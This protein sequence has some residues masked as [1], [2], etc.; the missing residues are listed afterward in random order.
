MRTCL[1]VGSFNPVTLAHQK[2][3]YDLLEDKVIDYLYFL[4]VNSMKNVILVEDRIKLLNLIK[5]PKMEVL[6][7]YDYEKKG[8]F[9]LWKR[10]R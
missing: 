7:I 10:G 2:I 1:F 3:A 9:N 4:P 6:N 5:T 8:L